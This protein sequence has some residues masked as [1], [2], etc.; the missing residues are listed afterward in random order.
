MLIN[1]RSRLLFLCF[2]FLFSVGLIQISLIDFNI[3]NDL[4]KENSEILIEINEDF[5]LIVP[6]QQYGT[7][8]LSNIKIKMESGYINVP[9]LFIGTVSPSRQ[10]WFEKEK[11]KNKY[12]I[13]ETI[14]NNPGITLREIQRATGLA[15][16]VVQYH[17]HNLEKEDNQVESYKLG[18]SKHF[19]NIQNIQKSH[20]EMLWLSI[21]RNTKVKNILLFLD[22]ANQK[23][24][25]Q[26]DIVIHTGFSKALVSYYIKNLKQQG[27]IEIDDNFIQISNLF[28][29]IR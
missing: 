9:I 12:Q 26:K 14:E 18:K 22:S 6:N 5:F 19:F 11:S 16:G 13:N 21:N 2:L 29:V 23:E 1:V 17:I 28:D 20:I 25:R 24:F 8:I 3:E 15:M 10:K 7:K 4:D 27:I